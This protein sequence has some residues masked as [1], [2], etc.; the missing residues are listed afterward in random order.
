MKLDITRAIGAVSRKLTFVDHEG[1]PAQS[2]VASRHYD[3]PIEDLWD[4]MTSAERLPR[5]F[6]P[7]E[8]DLRLGGRYQLKG[9]AGGEITEC[10][11]PTRLAVTW[12]MFGD[13]SWVRVDL[14]ESEG[15][16]T[17]LTL[18]HLAHTAPDFWNQYGPGA[19]GVGWDLALLGLEQ[20]FSDDPVVVPETAEEWGVSD[21]GKSF[22]RQSSEAWGEASIAA[23]T[24]PEAARTAALTTT[25]FYT[26]EA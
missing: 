7:I 20:H 13:T 23:G 2:I 10:D 22:S 4:A 6:L 1:K 5:W 18:E 14:K 21:E 19:T 25:K 16:G 24:D 11:P 9:N 17:E 8:G 12:E 26:G 3:T 15:G